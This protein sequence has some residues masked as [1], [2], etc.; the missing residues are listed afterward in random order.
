[1]EHPENIALN[2]NGPDHSRPGVFTALDV[3]KCFGATFLDENI[4]RSWITQKLHWFGE[5]CPKCDAG[6]AP[7]L[8]PSFW[9]VKRIKCERCGVIFTALTGTF[10]SG[11]HLDYRGIILLSL[12]LALGVQDKE[13]A[14][15]V[16]ISAE[17]VRLWRHKFEAIEKMKAEDIG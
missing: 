7:R 4:C 17:S 12:L 14:R 6:V 9:A 13:I 15:V 8:R 16:K 3:L 11:T 10:L 1:M 5:A 2:K